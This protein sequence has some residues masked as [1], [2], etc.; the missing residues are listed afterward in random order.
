MTRA[1]FYERLLRAAKTSPDL[2]SQFR[3]AAIKKKAAASAEA[4]LSSPVLHPSAPRGNLL[5]P[6]TTHQPYPVRAT[7]IDQ[8]AAVVAADPSSTAI[9]IS[10]PSCPDRVPYS[11]LLCLVA[12]LCAQLRP[13]SGRVVGLCVTKSLGEVVGVVAAAASGV[14]WTP[15]P[16]EMP[17]ARLNYIC[18]LC[19]CPA[20]ASTEQASAVAA[21]L[22]LPIIRLDAPTPPA[23]FAPQCHPADLSHI[24]F[25]SGSTGRPKGVL[26][27]HSS[28]AAAVLSDD[29]YS[30]VCPSDRVLHSVSRP[31]Y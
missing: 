8:L 10:D 22:N 23:A 16:P 2:F 15:L 28:L 6:N 1:E 29:S 21:S 13:F 14:A 18:Q 17:V 4:V 30:R 26:T 25:T 20:V 9:E 31:T 3:A 12:G 7:V 11:E 19:E 5:N 27:L 24:L